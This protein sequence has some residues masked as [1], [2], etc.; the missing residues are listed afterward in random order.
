MKVKE[1]LK[2]VK[3]N[4]YTYYNLDKETIKQ[5]QKLYSYLKIHKEKEISKYLW[6]LIKGLSS[7]Q[8]AKPNHKEY[9]RKYKLMNLISQTIKH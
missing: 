3:A 5:Y 8:I 6:L 2:E 4:R 7:S 9:T 1:L